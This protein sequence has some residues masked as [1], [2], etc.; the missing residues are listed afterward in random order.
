MWQQQ[1]AVGVTFHSPIERM[2]L[3][4]WYSGSCIFSICAH[5]LGALGLPV[6]VWLCIHS[7]VYSLLSLAAQVA[8]YVKLPLKQAH[9]C[10]WCCKRT[11]LW[12]ISFAFCLQELLMRCSALKPC[13]F[14]WQ[15]LRK[16]AWS[17]KPVALL[18]QAIAELEQNGNYRSYPFCRMWR[19]C[20]S[21]LNCIK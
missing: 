17:F 3:F 6:S 2:I 1:N 13:W 11:K 5:E 21:I 18:A 14:R 7:S 9:R 19:V 12:K 20:N 10:S 16:T 15:S 4:F 8:F